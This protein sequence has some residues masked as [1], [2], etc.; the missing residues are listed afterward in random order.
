MVIDLQLTARTTATTTTTTTT[1]SN[2][3]FVKKQKQNK[4]K[5]KNDG[6][7]GYEATSANNSETLSAPVSIETDA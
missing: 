2:F 7:R 6:Y 1:K 4:N 5:N 3:I